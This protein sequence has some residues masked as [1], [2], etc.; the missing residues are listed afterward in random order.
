M[1]GVVRRPLRFAPNRRRA[2]PCLAR[3]WHEWKLDPT[4]LDPT[5]RVLE[6]VLAL[7][8][9]CSD[10]KGELGACCRSALLT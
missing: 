2:E 9:R 10:V 4:K 7:A 8:V 3:R 6:L 5:C 1:V